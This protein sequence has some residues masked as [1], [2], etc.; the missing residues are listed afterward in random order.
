VQWLRRTVKKTQ[1][2]IACRKVLRGIH[3]GDSV[4][5]NGCCLSVSSHGRNGLTFDLLEETL[6]RTNLR[7]LR[8]ESGVNLEL[9]LRAEDRLGGHFVQGHVDGVTEILAAEE[10]GGDLRLDISLPPEAA[11][12]VVFKGSIAVNGVSLTVASVDASS[13]SVWLIPI[14]RADTNLGAA[15]VGQKVNLE[16]DILAKYVERM[17]MLREQVP[18]P[19][20]RT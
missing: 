15:T 4:A 9:P 5:V 19:P 10:K 8:P 12:Y 13:F 1:L 18:D 16:F 7:E 17:M 6:N 3:T 20:T 2:S 11:G 14:T